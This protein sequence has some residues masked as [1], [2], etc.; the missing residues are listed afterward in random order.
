MIMIDLL[1][2]TFL[3]AFLI[4]YLRLKTAWVIIRVKIKYAIGVL[5]VFILAAASIYLLAIA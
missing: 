2:V 3:A 1:I 5:Q 4:A